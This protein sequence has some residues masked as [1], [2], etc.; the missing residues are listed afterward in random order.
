MAI[1]RACPHAQIRV[2]EAM[3]DLVSTK[4]IGEEPEVAD[5]GSLTFRKLEFWAGTGSVSPGD[6]AGGVLPRT[7]R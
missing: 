5:D 2:L 7:L 4:C 6:P 1:F 3:A